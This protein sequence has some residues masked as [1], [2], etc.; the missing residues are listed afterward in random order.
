VQGGNVQRLSDGKQVQALH[1]GSPQ[2]RE[3]ITRP[4]SYKL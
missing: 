4:N 1:P 2:Q 3:F